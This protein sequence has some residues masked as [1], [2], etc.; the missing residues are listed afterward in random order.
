MKMQIPVSLFLYNAIDFYG[1]L[2]IALDD[3]FI[4]EYELEEVLNTVSYHLFQMY[5]KSIG[6]TEPADMFESITMDDHPFPVLVALGYEDFPETVW[7]ASEGAIGEGLADWYQEL[8]ANVLNALAEFAGEAEELFPEE[9]YYTELSE[10]FSSV[11]SNVAFVYNVASGKPHFKAST[12]IDTIFEEN[13]VS[14]FYQSEH[15]KQSRAIHRFLKLWERV[16]EIAVHRQ[17]L[18][19]RSEDE[20]ILAIKDIITEYSPSVA[21]IQQEAAPYIALLHFGPLRI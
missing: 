14:S 15:R 8:S 7:D 9:L 17:L 13:R 21:E 18:A 16:D 5:W 6:D 10:L 20:R 1:Q 19:V 2:I 3:Y 12:P 4:Y 11:I